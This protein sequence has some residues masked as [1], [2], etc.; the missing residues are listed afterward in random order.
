[1]TYDST[2][3]L[4]SLGLVLDLVDSKVFMCVGWAFG[5]F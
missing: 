3:N 1:M 4:H 5:L 2:E